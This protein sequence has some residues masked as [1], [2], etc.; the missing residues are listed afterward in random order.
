M[1]CTV[2]AVVAQ[3]QSNPC[4]L[5]FFS[6][7]HRSLKCWHWCVGELIFVDV[8]Y[9]THLLMR[10]FAHMGEKIVKYIQCGHS[11]VRLGV[12]V[13]LGYRSAHSLA[14]NWPYLCST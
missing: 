11:H 1:V 3:A 10:S 5:C 4:F 9:C 6:T 14:G 13:F 2:H 7:P 8:V 12:Y